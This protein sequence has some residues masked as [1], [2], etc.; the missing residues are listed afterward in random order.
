MFSSCSL[1]RIGAG[2]AG[3]AGGPVKGTVFAETGT[4]GGFSS[5]VHEWM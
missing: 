1:S 2:G 5:S 4:G 3:F